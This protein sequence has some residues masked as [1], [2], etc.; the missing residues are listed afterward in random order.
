MDMNTIFTWAH[1]ILIGGMF[2]GHA[3]AEERNVAIQKIGQAIHQLSLGIYSVAMMYWLWS[4][5]L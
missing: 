3:L 5:L 4:T 1:I 2:M